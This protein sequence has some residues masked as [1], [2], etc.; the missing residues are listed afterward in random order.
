MTLLVGLLAQAL[1]QPG[2]AATFDR[3]FLPVCEQLASGGATASLES[4]PMLQ[5]LKAGFGDDLTV[6]SEV[7]RQNR[8]R[9]E[10][11]MAELD[12][13]EASLADLVADAAAF[14]GPSLPPDLRINLVCGTPSDGYGFRVNGE[15]E[16]FL[17]LTR[18]DRDFMPH[19]LR[20]ELW[21]VAFRAAFPG[22]VAGFDRPDMPFRRLA[23]VM[24][25]EGVGHYY[26]F[27]R[28]VEPEITYSDWQGR[29]NAVFELLDR[30]FEEYKA[31]TSKE[32]HDALLWHSH[33]GVPFWQKWAAL[34][35]AVI[36]YRLRKTLGDEALKQVIATGPCAFLQLYQSEAQE[37]PEWQQLPDEL[38]ST[39]CSI[40]AS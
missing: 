37:R 31:A 28:L 34:P 12:A 24:L 21:H 10:G 22:H 30:K 4:H 1:L 16:L 5:K 9:L 39:A 40:G 3:S 33:A 17:D 29:T 7:V 13:L 6:S 19:L 25:N 18:I 8:T 35:G 20:H 2:Q 26:S 14:T 36:T 15:L 32:D 23:Y 27:R 38:V 11:Y